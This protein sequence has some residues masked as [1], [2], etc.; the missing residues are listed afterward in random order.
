MNPSGSLMMST[1][2]YY[3]LA[4]IT[5]AGF[6]SLDKH[7]FI[8]IAIIYSIL[9][10]MDEFL[11]MDWKNPTRQ[12][13]QSLEDN[14]FWF[15]FVVYFTAIIDWVLFFK[16]MDVFVNYEFTPFSILNIMGMVYIFS[17]LESAQFAIAHEIFHKQS[18]FD[19]FFGTVHMSKLLYMHFTYEHLWG[20]HKKVATPED[21]ASA[22]KGIN[23]YKFIVR[24]FFG[25]YKSVY[26]MEK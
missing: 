25:S 18:F 26:L 23:V 6:F 5:F 13:R 11:S 9:P 24:S 10:L 21:P 22:E 12:E 3:I 15:K 8:F 20:H 1:V 14:N 17:S 4:G 19:R 7:A 16:M 2:P